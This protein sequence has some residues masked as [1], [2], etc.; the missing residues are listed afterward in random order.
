MI[1]WRGSDFAFFA[2]FIVFPNKNFRFEVLGL[3]VT[4]VIV[5][6][7]GADEPNEEL[8]LIDIVGDPLT[9]SSGTYWSNTSCCILCDRSFCT[10]SDKT[11]VEIHCKRNRPSKNGANKKMDLWKDHKI[12]YSS[13][14]S[15]W[16]SPRSAFA[17]KDHQIK[18][19]V[20]LINIHIKLMCILCSFV[21]VKDHHK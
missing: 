2:S 3:D 1:Q 8:S 10:C 21:Q 6:C 4:L 15:L 17:P 12:A 19:K 20:I 13:S 7:V 9:C 5:V 16:Y 11:D 18:I 14:S